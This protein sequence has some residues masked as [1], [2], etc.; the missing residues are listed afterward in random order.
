MLML[1]SRSLIGSWSVSKG[2]IGQLLDE[3]DRWDFWY[4]ASKREI[5]E[6][7]AEFAMHQKEEFHNAQQLCYESKFKWAR[8]VFVSFIHGYKGNWVEDTSR[9]NSCSF[10]AVAKLYVTSTDYCISYRPFYP[11]IPTTLVNTHISLVPLA[12]LKLQFSLKN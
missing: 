11:W 8:H 7:T 2:A 12:Q 6:K 5:K 9:F 3:R 4:P 1:N 10:G